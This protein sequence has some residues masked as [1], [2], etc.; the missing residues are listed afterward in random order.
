[1]GSGKEGGGG[2]ISIL[3]RG[4]RCGKV[5]PEAPKAR[6][7]VG[8]VDKRETTFDKVIMASTLRL[9]PDDQRA[10]L[11]FRGAPSVMPTGHEANL[12][13]VVDLVCQGTCSDLLAHQFHRPELWFLDV[14]NGSMYGHGWQLRGNCPL[15][16]TDGS[17]GVDPIRYV[18]VSDHGIT[19]SM[20]S[21]RL[22]DNILLAYMCETQDGSVVSTYQVVTVDGQPV[23]EPQIANLRRVC[24]LC[25]ALNEDCVCLAI[26]KQNKLATMSLSRLSNDIQVNEPSLKGV[27]QLKSGTQM[28]SVL[29]HHLRA[30]TIIKSCRQYVQMCCSKKRHLGS[31]KSSPA[32]S[33]SDSDKVCRICGTEFLKSYHL[34]RHHESVHCGLKRHEC[35]FC[36]RTFSQSG[37]LNEHIRVFH[38]RSS[39]YRCEVCGKCFGAQSKLTR[40]ISAVH[41]N[42]RLFSCELCGKSFK[43]RSHVNKHYLSHQSKGY[44]EPQQQQNPTGSA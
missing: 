42:R 12:P 1:M 23:T 29:S 27:W 20:F 2:N 26:D 4:Q 3:D 18:V 9:I 7:G 10:W 32:T 5:H 34:R 39:S 35:Q 22:D 38:L 21:K 43:E 15:R 44:S 40:H 11:L 30:D 41:L 14:R 19:S 8:L 28:A 25:S 6:A 33:N 37:H 31:A 17:D 24:P 36:G 16:E 13:V